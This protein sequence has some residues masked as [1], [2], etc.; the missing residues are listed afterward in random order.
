MNSA[1]PSPF[2][3]VSVLIACLAAAAA[4][5][6]RQGES[7][8]RGAAPPA[9][10]SSGAKIQA[11]EVGDDGLKTGLTPSD[12]GLASRVKEKLAAEP[13]LQGMR[14]EVDAQGGRVTLWGQVDNAEARGAA[15][16]LA[17]QTPG[18]QSVSNL[19]DV[20]GAQARHGPS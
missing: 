11:V 14:L 7:P 5:G 4:C 13:R 8:P 19:I 18:A 1:A 17:R 10:Q 3:R 16:R 12:A 6:P 20:R 15:E 9:A 2:L